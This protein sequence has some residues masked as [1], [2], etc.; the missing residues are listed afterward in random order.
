MRISTTKTPPPAKDLMEIL[1][2]EFSGRYSYT[3]FGLGEKSVI[4]GK[5]TFVGAQISV[6]GNEI[7]IQATPPSVW[8]GLL[9]FIGL[10]ELGFVLI[11]FVVKYWAL[12]T[13]WKGL[14]KEIGLFLKHKYS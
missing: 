8:A 6:K 9:S 4:V 10:T 3:L 1:K 13:D 2:R 7:T 11:F 12:P 14:E 5:S